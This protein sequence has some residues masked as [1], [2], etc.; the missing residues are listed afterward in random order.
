M[1]LTA[2]LDRVE[3]ALAE[4]KDL[5]GHEACPLES[6]VKDIERDVLARELNRMAEQPFD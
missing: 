2:R 3:M 4:L 1:D 6:T 5:I